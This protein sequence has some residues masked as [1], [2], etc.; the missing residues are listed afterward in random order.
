MHK[1][2]FIE[3]WPVALARSTVSREIDLTR[4][5]ISVCVSLVGWQKYVSTICSISKNH[6]SLMA[7]VDICIVWTTNTWRFLSLLTW[8][9]QRFFVVQTLW[10]VHCIIADNKRMHLS[11]EQ[12]P[13]ILYLPISAL[14]F[15]KYDK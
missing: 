9:G 14:H 5:C 10:M 13:F 2:S 4:A 1:T 7:V 12:H 8:S 11:S 6:C 3:C 15:D